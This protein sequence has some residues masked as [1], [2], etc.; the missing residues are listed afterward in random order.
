MRNIKLIMSYDGSRYQGWQRL[1]RQAQTI[2]GKLEDTLRRILDEEITVSGSGRTDAGAHA[3]RQVVNFHCHSDMPCP[4]ILSL[5]RRYLPEDMGHTLLS[6]GFSPV[7]R[8][9]E[10]PGQDLR[11]P[12]LEQSRAAGLPAPV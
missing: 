1:P 12:H 9:A 10:R 7:P 11:I 5:L 6:G 3:L 8:P 4:E 2:Q